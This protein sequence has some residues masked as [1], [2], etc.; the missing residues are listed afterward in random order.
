MSRGS[1]RELL[2]N[3]E[4]TIKERITWNIENGH[5]KGFDR[6]QVLEDLQ[7]D[8]NEMIDGELPIYYGDMAKLLAENTRFADVEDS[9]ILPKNP[10]VWDI[11]TM[12]VYEWLS[13]EFFELACDAVDE[14]L[15]NLNDEEA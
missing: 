9:G 2:N 5:Y 10:T 11:I 1:E 14:L 3:L 15:P 12:S 7:D 6:D 13:S 4:S 8:S